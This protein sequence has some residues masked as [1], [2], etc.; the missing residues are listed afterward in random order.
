M[1]WGPLGT[2]VCSL[3]IPVY[4][5]TWRC[6]A[7]DGLLPD[8]QV[9]FIHHHLGDGGTCI[10]PGEEPALSLP[11]AVGTRLT[12]SATLSSVEL[13][14]VG[15]ATAEENSGLRG[16]RCA[17]PGVSGAWARF[18]A[19]ESCYHFSCMKYEAYVRLSIS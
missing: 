13:S 1:T 18:A 19:S 2:V 6:T 15:S 16:W 10:A 12:Q 11:V 8:C 9:G 17:P 14:S 7:G 4:R 5:L 3:R